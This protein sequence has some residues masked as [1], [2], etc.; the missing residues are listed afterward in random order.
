MIRQK[1]PR[2]GG[3]GGQ[4]GRH[5]ATDDRAVIGSVTPEVR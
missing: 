4:S 1:I 2:E 5:S 3:G